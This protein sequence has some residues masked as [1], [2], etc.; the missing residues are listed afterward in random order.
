MI[1]FIED[2]WKW[3][4]GSILTIIGLLIAYFQL[5]QSEPTKNS[6][7]SGKN[8]INIQSS[9]KIKVGEYDKKIKSKKRK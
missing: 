7:K 3:I 2:N 5:R 4:I 9:K 8:S 1:E 6:Q